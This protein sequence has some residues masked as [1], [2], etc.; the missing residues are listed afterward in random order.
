MKTFGHR[1]SL[2]VDVLIAVMV[3]GAWMC[4]VF[5]LG[6]NG[7]IS[8]GGFKNLKYFTVLSNLLAAAA[9]ILNIVYTTRA[10]KRGTSGGAQNGINAGSGIGAS[11]SINAQIPGWVWKTKYAAAT[12]VALTFIVVVSFLGPVYQIPGLYSG[13]NL[14]FHVVVPIVSVLAVIFGPGPRLEF[15]D[16]FRTLIPVLIYGAG[17][18]ANLLINGMGDAPYS[19]DWYGFLYW[20]WGIA[21]VMFAIMI[22]VSWGVALGMR[23]L[24]NRLNGAKNDN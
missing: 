12:A 13:A 22:L 6:D 8:Q 11:A 14:W 3:L 9:S 24:H 19:N 15:R 21:F 4:M 17:Y 5:K 1:T 23:A 16:S 10:I 20:G 2:A 18:I 7:T